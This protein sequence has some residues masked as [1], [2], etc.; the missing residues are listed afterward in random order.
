V[1]TLLGCSFCKK[2]QKEVRKLIAGPD[3]QICDECIVLS[4]QIVDEDKTA[5]APV[6]PAPA[7]LEIALDEHAVGQRPAKRALV[8]ALRRHLI[9]SAQPDSAERAPRVLLVGPSASGKT[10]LGRGICAVTGL[11]SYHADVSRLSESGYV[12]EDLENL[13]GTLLL[14]AERAHDRAERGVLF[15]DGI[16]K[17]K[18]ERPLAKSRDISGEGVQRE[19]IRLLDGLELNVPM[20]THR[21]HPQ[22]EVQQMSCRSIFVAASARLDPL[23]P[24]ASDRALRAALVATGILPEVLSRF[25]RIVPLPLPDADTLHALLHHAR[26]PVAA[27]RCVVE[28]LGGTLEIAPAAARALAEAAA[29]SADGAFLMGRIL[30]RHLEDVLVGPAPGRAWVIDEGRMRALLAE[31]LA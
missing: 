9:T 5:P 11:P 20:W 10:S 16:E 19:L 15:L 12:G 31:A 23:P 30:E 17:L 26:G 18:A 13:L 1:P 29:A 14:N 28:A 8:A 3:V 2:S 4:Q 21:R 22:G 24:R 27:A 25:D 7:D 6:V